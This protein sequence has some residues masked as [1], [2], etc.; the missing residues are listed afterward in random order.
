MTTPP[1]ILDFRTRADEPLLPGVDPVALR[2]EAEARGPRTL[3]A[4]AAELRRDTA[5]GGPATGG[6]VS[7]GQVS[8][9]RP[10]GEAPAPQPVSGGS[11]A[12][13]GTPTERQLRI[14]QRIAKRLGLP[15]EDGASAVEILRARGIDPFD[16]SLLIGA[17]PS[18]AAP[19]PDA[20][21]T[22]ETPTTDAGSRKLPVRATAAAPPRAPAVP[23]P[24]A[25]AARTEDGRQQG[26]GLATAAQ[27]VIA[28]QRDIARRRRWRMIGLGLRL[29]VLVVLPTLAAWW[30]YAEVATP[31][32]E[33]VSEFV[34][35]QADGQSTEAGLFQS[36]IPAL[37]QDS[38][39]VQSYLQSREAMLR[40]DDDKGFRSHFEGASVGPLFHVDRV[41]SNE[42]LYRLYRRLVKVSYDPTE[43]VLRMTVSATTPEASQTFSQALIGYAEDQVDKLTQRMREGQMSGAEAAFAAAEVRMQAAQAEILE[44]QEELGVLDPASESGSLMSQITEFELQLRQRQLQLDQLTAVPAPNGARVDALEGEIARLEEMIAGMRASMTEARGSGA[45]LARVSGRLRLAEA[46]LETRSELLKQAAAQLEAAR[47]DA[48]RQVRYMAVG[49]APIAPDEPT[50]PRVVAQTGLAFALFGGLYL[51]GALTASVLREQITA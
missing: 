1:E 3:A 22:T 10:S 27:E 37:Q 42:D 41:S 19:I 14:A 49:V 31:R 45:S 43:G 4:L 33:T 35:Q 47:I 50:A 15:V 38:I 26:T 21:G 44:L 2:A 11:P 48:D 29:A 7:G 18:G 6:Q 51:F 46:E 24:P 12:E 8:G 30:Y 34:I 23:A 16:R 28:I 5:E 13:L 20:A 40:L 32:Y 9:A 25:R 17:P 36:G 39:S